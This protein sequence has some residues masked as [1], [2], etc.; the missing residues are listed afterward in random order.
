MQSKY[1]EWILNT[2][3]NSGLVEAIKNSGGALH[4]IHTQKGIGQQVII[5]NPPKSGG[6][7]DPLAP[8]IPTTLELHQ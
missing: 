1:A 4:F 8:P 2:I 7:R 6:A 5:I 3:V